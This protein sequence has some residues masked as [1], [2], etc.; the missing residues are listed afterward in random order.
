MPCRVGITTD[1]VARRSYWEKQVVGFANWRILA[2][3]KKKSDALDHEERNAKR[4]GCKSHA[5]GPDKKGVWSVYK[6]DYVRIK[7]KKTAK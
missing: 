5:G 6:F 1:P 4:Y 3:Y 7:A 2:T